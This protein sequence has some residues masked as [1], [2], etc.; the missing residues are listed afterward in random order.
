MKSYLIQII[1][2]LNGDKKK[3]PFLIFLFFI[4]SM[5]DLI[6]IGLIG[7]YMAL[8]V[9][10]NETSDILGKAIDVLNFSKDKEFLLVFVGYVPSGV[11]NIM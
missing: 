4:S 1:Y 9:D 6:G 11:L 8:V 5:I 7:P 3:V 2:L 10:I